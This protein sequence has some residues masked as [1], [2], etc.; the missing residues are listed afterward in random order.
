MPMR[1]RMEREYAVGNL[2]LA[3]GGNMPD[4]TQQLQHHWDFF[5]P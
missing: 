1:H 3:L 2:V 4:P 5:N